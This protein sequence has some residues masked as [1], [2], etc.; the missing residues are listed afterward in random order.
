MGME[1]EGDRFEV[2]VQTSHDQAQ[3]GVHQSVPARVSYASMVRNS[4][5]GNKRAQYDL[6]LELD[7]VVV[8]DED[9]VVNHNGLRGSG[10]RFT[11]L[12]P[13]SIA[14]DLARQPTVDASVPESPLALRDSDKSL[15][16]KNKA[17]KSRGVRENV[18]KGLQIRKAVEAKTISQAVLSEWVDNV[19]SQL[20]SVA[21]HVEL[22][23]SRSIKVVVNQSGSLENVPLDDNRDAV[24]HID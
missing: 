13:E 1:D 7:R 3:D 16:G 8:M 9:C 6:D 24:R 21:V 5:R 19:T 18:Q 4:D 10:S 20:D 23:P 15:V 17:A 14:L 12:E 2:S 11:V 22:D